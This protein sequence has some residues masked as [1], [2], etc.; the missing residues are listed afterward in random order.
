[1]L[2]AIYK[3]ASAAIAN[4]IKPYLTQIIDNTQ[5]GFVPGRYIGECTRLIFDIMKFTED[6]RLPG[7]LVLI[8]FE[9]AFDSISWSFIYQTMTFLGFSKNLV[10]WVRLLN[11][12]IK[13]TIIQC[14]VLSDFIDIKRGC[15]Q[16]DPISPYLFII[17][18]QI[19][20]VLVKNNKH[21]QGITI[22]NIE[23]KL[24]QFADDTTLILDGSIESLRAAFNTLEIFGNISGLKVNKDK[25]QIAWIGKK[26]HSKEKISINNF[27]I[28]TITCFKLLGIFFSVELDECIKINFSQK[29]IELKELIKRWNK[30]YLTP[31]GKITIVKTFLLAKLNYLFTCLSNPDEV[32]IK[33]IN[34]LLFKFVWSSKPDK[35]NRHTIML[36]KKLGGLKMINIKDFVA[37]LKISWIWRLFMSSDKALWINVFEKNFNVTVAKA[38][39]F[40]A[41]FFQVLKNRTTNKF[42][43]NVFEAW[44]QLT[45]KQPVKTN[46]DL[47]SSPLWYSS[48]MTSHDI[49]IPDW[50]DKGVHTISDILHPN[51]SVMTLDEIKHQYS[52]KVIN[53]LHYL[54]IQ[55]V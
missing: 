6:R 19:L 40:G 15:R 46:I 42:W 20:T 22:G 34:D 10:Q 54:R 2:S 30:R 11:N 28:D 13:A 55:A 36:D 37:S 26:K 8:D 39:C 47:L 7:M 17:V 27:N 48:K 24:T 41:G 44:Q 18:A 31:L 38:I 12:N 52:I 1:M 53:P 45:E 33:E 3:L 16:G 29:M 51:R 23:I 25:T 43:I 9:K 5:S 35:I 50:F 32:Y 14:G 49:Y 4:R 21:I